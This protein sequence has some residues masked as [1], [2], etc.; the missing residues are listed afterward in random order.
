MPVTKR[1]ARILV[2]LFSCRPRIRVRRQGGIMVARREKIVQIPAKKAIMSTSGLAMNAE[3][4]NPWAI[5]TAAWVPPQVGQGTP[6]ISRR[7]QLAK[8]KTNFGQCRNTKIE[9]NTIAK[10][11][12]ASKRGKADCSLTRCMNWLTAQTENQ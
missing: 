11:G 12:K 9:A 5:S 6:V 4:Q 8:S 10:R 2:A 7:G 1:A 3:N